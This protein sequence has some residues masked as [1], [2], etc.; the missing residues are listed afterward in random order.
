M[1]CSLVHWCSPAAM[2]IAGGDENLV[3]LLVG[4][5][6]VR[7]VA[8]LYRLRVKELA[9]LP[10]M[11]KDSAQKFFDAITAS[12]KREAWRVLFGLGI[13][14]IGAV[15]AQLFCQ[16]FP[17]LDALFATG[18]ERLMQLAGVTEVM[19][20]SLTHWHGDSVNRKLIRRLEKV[21]VNFKTSAG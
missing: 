17:T 20:R 12:M 18:R 5:G 4:R 7:E 13:P 19:A 15:E 8:E 10:G 9:A 16:H 21:G 1:R 3:A 11:D 6:L 2:D 14:G